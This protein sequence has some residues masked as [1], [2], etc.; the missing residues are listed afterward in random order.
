[1]EEKKLTHFLKNSG[2]DVFYNTFPYQK[3]GDNINTCGRH[4]ALRL[5]HRDLSDIQYH[6]LINKYSKKYNL[7]IDETVS[8]LIYNILGK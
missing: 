7:N 6:N 1:M 8:L 3:L 5:L 4:C 2:Y